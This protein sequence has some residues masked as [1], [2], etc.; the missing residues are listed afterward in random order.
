[1]PDL[2]NREDVRM[3]QGRSGP[4]LLLEAAQ[5]LFNPGKVAAHQFE[6]H[7]ATEACIMSQE[8]F[9]HTTAP[10]EAQYFIMADVFAEDWTWLLIGKHLGSRFSGHGFDGISG[11]VVRRDER[12]NFA[13]Q[14]RIVSAGLIQ[15]CG[16]L[17]RISL[18]CGLENLFYLLPPLWCHNS[19]WR[20]TSDGRHVSKSKLCLACRL[21]MSLIPDLPMEPGLGHAPFPF[22]CSG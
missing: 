2:V 4:R 16:A 20:V 11:V 13:S 8:Y 21:T 1:M 12:F 18:K 14:R 3:I 9:T 22:D 19:Q 15:K 5:S 17:R 6:R 10:E 7:L